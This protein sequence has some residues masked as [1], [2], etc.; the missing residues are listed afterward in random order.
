LS[1]NFVL[2]L[3]SPSCSL[4][5]TAVQINL[6]TDYYANETAWVLADVL[7]EVVGEVVLGSLNSDEVYQDVFCLE[8]NTYYT[9]EISDSY[10]DGLVSEGYSIVICGETIAAGADFDDGE[11]VSFIAGCD[12]SLEVGCTDPIASNYNME[13][14]VDDGSCLILSLNDLSYNILI[15]PNPAVN[16]IKI[17]LADLEVKT[18]LV[19][20]MDGKVVKSLSDIGSEIEFNITDLDSG[21][22]L[23]TLN[24]E[25]GL[26][27]TKSIIVM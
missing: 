22:Y 25:N 10:G 23:M 9:F 27:I 19:R 14:I 1:A 21:Y 17:E 4:E 20:Q 7:A 11:I 16:K 8:P 13:A 26:T 3:T 24:L 5:N 12:Q 15:Y 18:I 6:A 2:N